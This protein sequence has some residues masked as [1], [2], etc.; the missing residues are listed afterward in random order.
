MR[1]FLLWPSLR[2]QCHWLLFSSEIRLKTTTLLTIHSSAST[3]VSWELR[4]IKV[5]VHSFGALHSKTVDLCRIDGF[6]LLVL[7]SLSSTSSEFR[8]KNVTNL[9]DFIPLL[10]APFPFRRQWRQLLVSPICF[11]HPLQGDC[12][13][14]VF[15]YCLRFIH[16]ELPSKWL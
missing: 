5:T 15:I 2:H 16:P 11:F 10:F 7:L 6:G 12:I 4:G 13:T 14:S 9:N 3:G 8:L 1:I